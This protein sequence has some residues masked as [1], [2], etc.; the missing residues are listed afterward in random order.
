MTSKTFR[1][2]ALVLLVISAIVLYVVFSRKAN[3][4]SL[5]GQVSPPV[6]VSGKTYIPA[7][8]SNAETVVIPQGQYGLVTCDA[9]NPLP[10]NYAVTSPTSFSN[11]PGF[12]AYEFSKINSKTEK[13]T[14]LQSSSRWSGLRYGYGGSNSL[15]QFFSGRTYLVSADSAFQ[16]ACTYNYASSSSAG[17]TITAIARWP[18]EE[19]VSSTTTTGVGVSNG[20][21]TGGAQREAG[22]F[23]ASNRAITFDGIDDAVTV[24]TTA[25]Q[26]DFSSPFSITLWVR[27]ARAQD[28]I[29]LSKRFSSSGNGYEIKLRSDNKV[30][31]I[32]AESMTKDVRF[33][34]AGT[35]P[36]DGKFHYVVMTYNPQF[37]L[38]NRGRIYIDQMDPL[39]VPPTGGQTTFTSTNPAPATFASSANLR[40]GAGVG[41]SFA[42]GLDDINIYNN[43]ITADV[44]CF[45]A[46][47]PILMADGSSKPIETVKEGDRVQ[48]IDPTTGKQT[49]AKVSTIFS[50]ISEKR[51]VLKTPTRHIEVTPEHPFRSRGIWKKAGDLV[52]GDVLTLADGTTDTVSSITPV[53]GKAPVFNMTVDGTHTYFANDV[54]VHNKSILVCDF[55]SICEPGERCNCSSDCGCAVGKF[56]VMSGGTPSCS[57]TPGSSS[58]TPTSA[59]YCNHTAATCGALCN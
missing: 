47:T 48:S 31:L 21:I 19:A 59:C 35:V 42:G 51:V 54:L 37:A 5:T 41:T 12:K 6:T 25:L 10:T 8:L 11:V 28:A 55:D 23:L 17:G 29:L 58:S 36:V 15:T 34:S 39:T 27:S 14:S 26:F 32:L 20:T 57:A 52:S 22:A 43:I 24:S 53:T 13:N 1:Q 44:N 40:M 38:A 4:A 33:T 56:C 7:A 2:L 18:L 45:V 9:G 46:G 50:R 49:S 30:E 16:F 3:P